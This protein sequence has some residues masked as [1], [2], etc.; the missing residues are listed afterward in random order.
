MES[1]FKVIKQLNGQYEFDTLFIEVGKQKNIVQIPIV[2]AVS[3]GKDLVGKL[4]T[5]K[6]EGEIDGDIIFNTPLYDLV[7]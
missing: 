2:K 1:K 4:I 6:Y 3:E 5:V 7:L